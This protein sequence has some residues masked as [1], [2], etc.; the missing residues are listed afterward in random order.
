VDAGYMVVLH[1]THA[2][3]R[4]LDWYLLTEKGAQVLLAWHEAG[5]S[6]NLDTYRVDH[7]PPQN[8]ES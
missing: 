3:P 5:Y 1:G 7:S 2:G 8:L 6:A 4:C